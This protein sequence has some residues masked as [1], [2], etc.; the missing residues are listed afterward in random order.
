MDFKH[1]KD[2]ITS[3]GNVCV[4][5]PLGSEGPQDDSTPAASFRAQQAVLFSRFFFLTK[6]N[7][8]HQ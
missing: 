7:I 1:K 6:N 5:F 4:T 3:Q 8:H 2:I